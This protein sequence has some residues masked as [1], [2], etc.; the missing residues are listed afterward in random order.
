MST[1]RGGSDPL[2]FWRA[3]EGETV[4]TDQQLVEG[5]R[6]GDRRAW[7]RL[8]D[9]Y[10]RLVYSIP[11]NL[12]L[13]EADAEDVAQATFAAFLSGIDGIHTGER[14]GAWLST[15][16]RRQSIRVWERRE[17][18]RAILASSSASELD[19]DSWTIRV[20]EIEWVDQAL[21][22]LSERCRRL[23]TTLYFTEPAPSYVEAAERLGLPVGSIGPTRGR[24]LDALETELKRLAPRHGDEG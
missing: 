18:D 19:H 17:R 6:V 3:I 1:D 5:C 23:L 9:R 21:A 14:L 20:E 10:G 15:V 7:R 22:A 8:L 13:S 12:G 4:E 16:A 11:R 2:P 24:C